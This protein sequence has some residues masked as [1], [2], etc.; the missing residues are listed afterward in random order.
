M[1]NETAA[2]TGSRTS[3]AR[4]AW[5]GAACALGAAA[6][7][8]SGFGLDLTGKP[9][10][11]VAESAASAPA[12][13]AVELLQSASFDVFS[14]RMEEIMAAASVSIDEPAGSRSELTGSAPLPLDDPEW[15]LF[16]RSRDYLPFLVRTNA[17]AIRPEFLFRNQF[18]NPTDIY[19]PKDA[20][21]LVQRMIDGYQKPLD[22][23]RELEGDAMAEEADLAIERG[24]AIERPT[25]PATLDDLPAAQREEMERRLQTARDQ[26]AE[27]GAPADAIQIQVQSYPATS[28]DGFVTKHVGNAVYQIPVAALPITSSCRAFRRYLFTEIGL[29]VLQLFSQWGLTPDHTT[30]RFAERILS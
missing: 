25:V 2:V 11:A 5:C 27:A 23:L 29:R 16:E 13:P 20:R 14:R 6:A 4:L 19:I 7:I 21:E 10:A 8:A 3:L 9:A 24:L 30:N 17:A 12:A 15:A 28:G 26:A 22:Q 18:L 1:S